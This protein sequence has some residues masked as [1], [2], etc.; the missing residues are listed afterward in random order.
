[1]TP[2]LYRR[3]GQTLG[4]WLPPM[5]K[6]VVGGDGRDSTPAFQEAL[7]DG[8]CAAGLDVI[9]LGQLPTPMIYHAKNRVQAEG[10]AIVTASHNPAGFNGL[11]WLLGDDPPGPDEVARLRQGAEGPA[12]DL[13][14]R[15]RSKPRVLDVSFDYVAWLQ[16][17]F[18]EALRARRHIVLDPM[19]GCWAARARRYLNAIFPEC[20][21]TAI[22]DWND[23]RFEGRSPDCSRPE[24]LDELCEAVYRQR[25]DLGVAFDGDGDRIALVDNEGMALNAEEAAWALLQTFGPQL[26]GDRFVYDLKFSDR[27]RE[28]AESAGAEAIMERSGHSFLR[29]RMRQSEALFGAET[30]GHYFFRELEGGDDG[31]L[32]VCRLI[33]YLGDSERTMSDLRRSCPAAFITPDLR[34]AVNGDGGLRL[35]QQIRQSW[36]EHPQTTIDGVRI[37]LPGGWALVRQSVTEPA[38]TFRFESADWHGLDHLVGRFCQLLPEV[39]PQLW[40]RYRAAMGTHD[41]ES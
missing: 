37:E 36:S 9:N 24:R 22:H 19:H 41:A 23:A 7:I 16:E 34:L 31:L 2:E 15:S 38:L 18:V 26:R 27:I 20:L 39:G 4:S 28:A 13:D 1:L 33:A 29:A 32:A 12:A 30:S 3:W 6:F 35:I 25:A 8:L 10:C 5:A 17:M 14:G 40:S 21:L 11:K